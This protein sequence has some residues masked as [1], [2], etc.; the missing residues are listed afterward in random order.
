MFYFISQ[1]FFF[2][3]LHST[4]FD[5]ITLC[6]YILFDFSLYVGS[7]HFRFIFYGLEV[8]QEFAEQHFY[9]KKNK[10]SADCYLE[11]L[12]SF[13]LWKQQKKLWNLCLEKRINC[14]GNTQKLIFCATNDR[15]RI[16]IVFKFFAYSSHIQHAC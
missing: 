13:L 8:C 7:L 4:L 2:H 5:L 9:T 11:F 10:T 16:K 14:L 3:I 12:Q 6:K 1:L 15:I